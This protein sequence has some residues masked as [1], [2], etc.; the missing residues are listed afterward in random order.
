MLIGYDAWEFSEDTNEDVR[1]V[2]DLIFDASR[3]V[4]INYFCFYS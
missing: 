2:G 3:I 4:D 1:T